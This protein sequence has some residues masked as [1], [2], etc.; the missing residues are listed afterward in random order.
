[1]ALDRANEDSCFKIQMSNTDHYEFAYQNSR[2]VLKSIKNFQD[3]RIVENEF[4]TAVL[5]INESTVCR[6]ITEPAGLDFNKKW[7]AFV[8]PYLD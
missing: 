4:M 5:G 6:F 1:M 2:W 3:K 8:K 7:F